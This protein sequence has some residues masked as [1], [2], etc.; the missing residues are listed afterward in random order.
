M[1]RLQPLQPRHAVAAKLLLRLRP[2][3]RQP[4]R[5]LA[6]LLHGGESAVGRVLQPLLGAC[7]R[8]LRPLPRLPLSARLLLGRLL[9]LARLVCCSPRRRRRRRLRLRHRLGRRHRGEGL[10]DFLLR[11]R[12][13]LGEGA[14]LFL[15]RPLPLRRLEQ[16]R[17]LLPPRL[18]QR[19]LVGSALRLGCVRRGPP[20]LELLLHR[21]A[22]RLQLGV[23]C[24]RRRLRLQPPLLRVDRRRLRRGE[25]RRVRLLALALHFGEP[26]LL[27][28]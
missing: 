10:S 5:L 22:R 27:L 16:P 20:L 23:L 1:L 18:L 21:R 28:R 13:L 12:R 9:P 24:P 15:R 3:R 4:A 2:L 17:L 11:P 26:R 14:R 7:E 19:R 25:H 8:R 6:G